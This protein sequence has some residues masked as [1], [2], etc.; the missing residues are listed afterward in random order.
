MGA[1][2][3]A[4]ALGVRACVVYAM[5]SKVT[6]AVAHLQQ[7]IKA[8]PAKYGVAAKTDA[9]LDCLRKNKRFLALIGERGN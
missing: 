4:T 9:D 3:G 7:A 1:K 5:Q 6:L 2:G 8:N